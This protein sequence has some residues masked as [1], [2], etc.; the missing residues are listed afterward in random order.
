MAHLVS[1]SIALTFLTNESGKHKSKSPSTIQVKNQWKTI[2]IEEKLDVISPLEKGEHT[3]DIWCNVTYG[4]ICM[5]HGNAGR[6]IESA[7]SG[8]EMSAASL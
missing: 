1:S 3:V 4:S 2:G 6:I 7:K 5:I 8:P